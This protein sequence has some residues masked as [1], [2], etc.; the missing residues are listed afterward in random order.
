MIFTQNAKDEQN[1]IERTK[2]LI[3]AVKSKRLMSLILEP[4]S[5]CNLSCSFCDSH[6]SRLNRGHYREGVMSLDLYHRIM[7]D[8]DNI[9]FKFETVFFHGNGEPLLSKYIVDM[10][11]IA[12]NRKIA[13]R[14]VMFTNGTLMEPDIFDKLVSSGINEI[15]ISIDIID[16][17]IYKKVKGKDLLKN[18]LDNIDY[19]IKQILKSPIVSLVIKSGEGGDVYGMN[20]ENLQQVINRY[21]D[22]VI[23]SQY[24]HI[25]NSPIVE[26]IDGMVKQKREYQQ[27]CE[28]PFYMAYIK[29]DGRVSPCCGDIF[30]MLNIG[31]IGQES[32]KDILKGQKLRKIRETHLS[33]N[34][35]NIPLC[36][37]CGNRT[38]VD[39]S[40]HRDEL[41][42]LI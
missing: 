10:V 42:H 8:I 19:G 37:Y 3:G 13:K 30:D 27:P 2:N 18:V 35:D 16:P 14:Y 34:L 29:Y 9:G 15:N 4:A 25:K 1:K 40:C 32:F 26:L 17:D 24:I 11:S 39:L 20:S 41:L 38:V 21:R 31:I 7:D 28:I 6:S 33:G 36:K 22:I 23:N 12:V 5:I